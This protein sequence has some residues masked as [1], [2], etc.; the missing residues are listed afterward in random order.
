[1]AERVGEHRNAAI[2]RLT[3]RMLQHRPRLGGSV[4]RGLKVVDNNVQMKR[5]PVPVVTAGVL[6]GTNLTFALLQ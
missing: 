2:G 3:Y 5:S 1:M 4:D 6:S